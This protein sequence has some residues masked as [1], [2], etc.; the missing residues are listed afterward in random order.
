MLMLFFL[1]GIVMVFEALMVSN[2]S[3]HYLALYKQCY[4][5]SFGQSVL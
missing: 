5:Y 4:Q 3:Q 2:S 1:P